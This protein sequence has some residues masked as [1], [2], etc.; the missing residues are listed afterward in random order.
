MYAAHEY[1]TGHLAANLTKATKGTFVSILDII[2]AKIVGS[3]LIYTHQWQ[4]GDLLVLN[5]P[6]LAHIAGPGSQGDFKVTGLR[7]MHRS[8]VAG[9]VKPSKNPIHGAVPLEYHCFSHPPFEATEY[10][11]FS[12]KNAVFYPRYGEFETKEQQRRRCQY[13]HAKVRA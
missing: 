4:R 12:L 8:T 3:N 10:C 11:L 7:L 5:N 6:S 13:I 9:K 1:L 2:E